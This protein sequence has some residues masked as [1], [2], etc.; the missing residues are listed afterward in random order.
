[1]QFY[2]FRKGNIIKVSMINY[3]HH[4]IFDSYDGEFVYFR[5]HTWPKEQ[6]CKSLACYV[7]AVETTYPLMA[8]SELEDWPYF[9]S[10]HEIQNSLT[11]DGLEN[12]DYSKVFKNVCTLKL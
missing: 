4:V 7:A 8:A 12:I 11:D 3:W 1:M 9:D 5:Y 10:V 6:T 2:D